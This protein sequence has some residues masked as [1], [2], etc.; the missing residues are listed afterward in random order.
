MVSYVNEFLPFKLFLMQHNE[1]K[2]SR[3]YKTQ[4]FKYE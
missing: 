2:D 4:V 3:P 1:A